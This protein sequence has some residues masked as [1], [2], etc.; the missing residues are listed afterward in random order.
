VTLRRS[1]QVSDPPR[2][3]GRMPAPRKE[4]PACA[5][6]VVLVGAH[7]ESFRGRVGGGELVERD[8]ARPLEGAARARNGNRPIASRVDRNPSRGLCP[9]VPI[10]IRIGEIGRRKAVA[11]ERVAEGHPGPG[12]VQRMK[13]RIAGRSVETLPTKRQADLDAPA[14]VRDPGRFW[15]RCRR[16]AGCPGERTRRTIP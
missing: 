1:H 7:D 2:S 9:H 13:R 6:V 10:D 3:I 14:T 5:R 15:S 8:V 4:S 16:S 12:G 11:A